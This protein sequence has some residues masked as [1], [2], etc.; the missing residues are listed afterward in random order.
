MTRQT[1]GAGLGLSIV[2]ALVEAHGGEL[3]VESRLGEGSTFWF[4]LP[5]AGPARGSVSP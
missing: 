2:K 3:G 4:T 5:K 1:G